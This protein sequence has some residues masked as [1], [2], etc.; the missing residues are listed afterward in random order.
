MVKQHEHEIWAVDFDGT[1]YGHKGD[2]IPC[3]NQ[4]L[5]DF[6]YEKQAKG[7]YII[8]WTCRTDIALTAAL[9]LINKETD[10]AFSAVNDNLDFIKDK[11]NE[12]GYQLPRKVYANYYIDD[13]N[14]PDFNP[15]PGSV[16][17]GWPTPK[18]D[19]ND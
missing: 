5:L 4:E 7:D 17:F 14:Y 9:D 10:L 2:G 19:K 13:K 12:K 18:D 1:L 16:R 6:L 11:W 8:L 3:W 15:L